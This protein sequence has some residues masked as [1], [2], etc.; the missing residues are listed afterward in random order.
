MW[1]DHLWVLQ[2]GYWQVDH[3]AFSVYQ[4]L[5][6]RNLQEQELRTA[7]TWAVLKSVPPQMY[8]LD[9]ISVVASAIG[10]PLHTEKARLDP[11]HFGDTKVKIEI[12]LDN[13]PPKLVEVRDIQGN[14]VR[15]KVD[16]PSLPPKCLNCGKYGYPLNRCLKPLIKRKKAYVQETSNQVRMVS[17]STK[18]SLNS[19]KVETEEISEVNQSAQLETQEKPSKNKKSKRRSQKEEEDQALVQKAWRL[20]CPLIQPKPRVTLYLLNTKILQLMWWILLSLLKG[21]KLMS[22][23]SSWMKKLRLKR[24]KI[25]M[26]LILMMMTDCGLS[27]L[28]RSA[29][30]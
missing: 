9:G 4:W 23:I 26:I 12:T 21:K 16:Y 27:T 29:E 10:E 22:L 17:T 13:D 8:S 6:E 18:I 2:V 25:N 11:Y 28:R 1:K 7:P 19:D 3:R 15:I 14:S 30:L 5:A 24:Y 20:L